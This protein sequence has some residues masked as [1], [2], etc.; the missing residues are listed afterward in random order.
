MKRRKMEKMTLRQ[1]YVKHGSHA[2]GADDI[3]VTPN[4][5]QLWLCGKSKPSWRSMQV[6]AQ[7]KISLEM[8]PD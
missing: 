7:K 8:F 6:L 5:Y 2:R 4:M 1:H 3:G